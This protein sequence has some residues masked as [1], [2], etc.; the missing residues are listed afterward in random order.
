MKLKVK[1]LNNLEV[2]VEVDDAASILDLMKAVEK[3][4]PAM[5]SDRQKLIHSG[6]VLKQELKLSDYADIKDGDKV[7]VI[8]SK[9]AEAKPETTPKAEAV[10]KPAVESHVQQE[11]QQTTEPNESRLVTG[12]E[13]EMNIARICEMGFP[14]PLVERAMAAAF[15]NPERA[16]EFLSTGNIPTHSDMYVDDEEGEQPNT[17]SFES[18]PGGEGM[19]DESLMA[20]QSHPYFQQ[21]RQVIQSDPQMLQQLLETIGQNN[22]ELLQTILE[23]QEE[24]MHI[25]NTGGEGAPYSESL[26]GPNVIQLTDQEIESVQRLEGLG[27]P[28][29]AVIEAYLACDKNEELAA[30]YLLEH[31]NDMASEE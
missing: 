19:T 15:N 23:N 1:T 10:E 9:Q 21:L 20:I 3:V 6:K 18:V 31:S 24:F 11:S 5:P 8:A 14:R 17:G 7:I 22:P 26:E 27:F 12:S 25:L 29:S 30:N 28:R 16:V 4:L 2:D 13:L